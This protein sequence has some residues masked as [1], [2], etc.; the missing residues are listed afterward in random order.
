MSSMWAY[1]AL[2]PAARVAVRVA[3]ARSPKLRAGLAGRAGVV[4]RFAAFGAQH[5]RRCVWMHA[6]S[7][8][9]YEQLRPVAALFG[10]RRPDLAVLHTFFSPSGYQYAARL[11]EAAHFDYVPEDSP[12]AVRRALE[13]VRPR[14][15]VFAKFDLWP[16][17]IASAADLGIPVLLI[18]ATLRPRSWRS[19]WPARGF[20]RD[21]YARLRVVSAVSEADAARFRAV[22]PSHPGIV[23]D[24]DTRFDQVVRRRRAA[25]RV[26][27]APAFV[28]APRAWTLVAGSTW[29]PDEARLVP[30]FGALARARGDVRLIVVPHEP[31]AAHL[32]PLER[33]LAAAGLAARRYSTLADEDLGD[34]RVVVVDRVGILAELYAL[35]DAAYVGGAFTTG[36]HN[37]LE[38]AIA[39]IPVAFGP[40]HH[41]APEAEMLLGAG[42][43]DV[44][45]SEVDLRA[46]LAAWSSD[47]QRAAA[48]GDRAR[49][50]VEAHLGASERC[51]ARLEHCLEESKR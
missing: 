13:L 49:R 9:E 40:R 6:A 25:A 14:A 36:V 20:Y 23:V 12:G 1:N 50:L 21:L 15:L 24:G 43:A 17:L 28:R 38:P 22:V 45:R 4:E 3:A 16:N 27:L 37:V 39:G 47:P 44:I 41:N 26:E 34:A 2:L 11:R 48:R 32:A 18:D 31:T 51:V 29:G 19:R 7:V 5:R 35:G 46:L 33:A 30:A 8:G 42:A 10:E